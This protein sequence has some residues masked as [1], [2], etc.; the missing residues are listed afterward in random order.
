MP[1]INHSSIGENSR[2][3]Q[4]TEEEKELRKKELIAKYTATPWR[5]TIDQLSVWAVWCAL[6]GGLFLFVTVKAVVLALQ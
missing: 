6:A 5:Y 2:K 4:I 3:I 1:E